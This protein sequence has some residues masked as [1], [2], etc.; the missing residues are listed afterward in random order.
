MRKNLFRPFNLGGPRDGLSFFVNQLQWPFFNYDW[1]FSVI[2][3]I[4]GLKSVDDLRV[5][6]PGAAMHSVAVVNQ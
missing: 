3:V 1:N 4:R 5:D 2:T 6:G